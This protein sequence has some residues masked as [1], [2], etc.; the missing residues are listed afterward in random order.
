M[1]PP[2]SVEWTGNILIEQPG[3]YTFGLIA[4]DGAVLMIDGRVVVDVSHLLLQKGTGTINLSAGLH[5]IQVRYFNTLFG[6]LTPHLKLPRSAL[7][8]VGVQ[9]NLTGSLFL[10]VDYIRNVNTHSVL[11]RDVNFVGAASTLD[12]VAAQAAE[13]AVKIAG[14]Q[15]PGWILP[16][17]K[18]APPP[19]RN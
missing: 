15:P 2:F 13:V 17:A 12:P 8:N 6:V 18:R 16:C 10:S 4:D 9:R 14:I 11:N 7:F 5:P 1:P 19:V 3:S